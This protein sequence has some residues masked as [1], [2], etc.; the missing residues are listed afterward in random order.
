MNI[1]MPGIT[2]GI[3]LRVFDIMGMGGFVLTN[4][5]PEVEEL[6]EIGKNIEVYHDF[7]EMADKVKFYSDNENARKIIALNGK[8]IIEGFSIEKRVREILVKA[9]LQ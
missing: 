8:K 7:D 4:Y 9:G 5:Q 3:P 2:S 6:F 1:T